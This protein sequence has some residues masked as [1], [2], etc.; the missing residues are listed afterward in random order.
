MGLAVT[1][2]EK[3]TYGSRVEGRRGARGGLT[4]SVQRLDM[5]DQLVTLIITRE[6]KTIQIRAR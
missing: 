5:F 1:K 3:Q 2:C 4:S 6:P